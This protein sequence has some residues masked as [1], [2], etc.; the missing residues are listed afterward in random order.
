MNIHWCASRLG[1]VPSV[2]L[3]AKLL[4]LPFL[5][6]E[7]GLIARRCQP[8]VV[9]DTKSKP[10][11]MHVGKCR[12]P[13]KTALRDIVRFGARERVWFESRR[14]RWVPVE[15]LKRNILVFSIH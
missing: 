14:H 4:G 6:L 5:P 12:H 7:F 1:N 13:S 9:V 2:R 15:E 10:A 11:Q 8:R 3:G